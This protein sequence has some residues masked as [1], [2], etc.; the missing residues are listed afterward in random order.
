MPEISRFLGIVIA[1]Y[2]REHNPP[3][4]H[5]KYGGHEVV[6]HLQDGVVEGRF[7]RRA[8]A[9]VMEWY[10]IHRLELIEDWSLAEQRKPLKPIDPLE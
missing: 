5:A 6:V 7:P 4:F 2:Y 8:L 3:H 1:M 10:G 9:H